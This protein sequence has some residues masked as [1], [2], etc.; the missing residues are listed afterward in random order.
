[1]IITINITKDQQAVRLLHS[2]LETSRDIIRKLLGL[3]LAQL[4]FKGY[5]MRIL[6]MKL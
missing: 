1:M 5:I 2:V 6:L 4:Q 3:Y